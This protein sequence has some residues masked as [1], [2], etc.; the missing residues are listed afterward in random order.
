[1]LDGDYGVGVLGT[2]CRLP[3][4]IEFGQKITQQKPVR[5]IADKNL[6]GDSNF[7]FYN[8]SGLLAG[9]SR[10]SNLIR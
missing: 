1:M 3:Y 7:H 5:E 9:D 4:R 10:I 2:G 8:S 6:M